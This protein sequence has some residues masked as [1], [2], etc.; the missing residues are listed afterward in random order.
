MMTM[1]KTRNGNGN[2][3]PTSLAG[4][5]LSATCPPPRLC[6]GQQ[7]QDTVINVIEEIGQNLVEK[8]LANP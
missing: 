1:K 3:L 7:V 2:H 5:R 4:D 6:G 8:K